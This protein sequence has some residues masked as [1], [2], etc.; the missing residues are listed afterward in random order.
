MF[1]PLSFWE[2]LFLFVAALLIFGPRKLPELGK[3]LGKGLREF[4]RASEDLKSNWNEHMREAENPIN[5]VRQSLN[6]VRAEVEASANLSLDEEVPVP[7]APEDVTTT[8][9]E[10]PQEKKPDVSTN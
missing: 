5:E 9:P 10:E 1:G 6:D 8:A 7:D 4:K 2:V 3:T